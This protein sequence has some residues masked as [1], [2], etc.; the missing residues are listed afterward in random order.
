MHVSPWDCL[1]RPH[2]NPGSV[3]DQGG[4]RV[5]FDLLSSEEQAHCNVYVRILPLGSSQARK[6]SEDMGGTGWKCHRQ[7]L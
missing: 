6:V 5:Y 2:P 7:V 4:G 3:Q 1:A